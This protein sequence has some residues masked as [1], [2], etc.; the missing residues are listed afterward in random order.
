[1]TDQ[2]IFDRVKKVTVEKLSVKED[3]V[4]PSA[5]FQEDLG[6]DSLDVVELVMALE[7]EFGIE[8]PDDDVTNLKT[9]QNAVDY[10]KSKQG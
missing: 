2:E 5:S 9:V 8:I 7:E 10:I 3:E 4:V 1:M 6:A